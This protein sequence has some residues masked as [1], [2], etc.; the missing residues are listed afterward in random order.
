MIYVDDIM[1]YPK[2]FVAKAAKK[3]GREWCHLWCDP[4]EEEQL[5]IL[6]K[7]IGLSRRWYQTEGKYNHY[8]LTP[9]KRKLA[10]KHGAII[11]SFRE[12]LI[13]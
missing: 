10:V 2:S 13:K 9:Y 5:H 11:M 7:K 6:A 4:K 1:K 12:W 8:D 3:H